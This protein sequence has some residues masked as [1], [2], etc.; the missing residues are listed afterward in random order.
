MKSE[1]DLD[2][3][4]RN[5]RYTYPHIFISPRR[6]W[7]FLTPELIRDTMNKLSPY[8]YTQSN[9]DVDIRLTQAM[10]N[11][12]LHF[13]DYH[14]PLICDT[15]CVG[16]TASTLSSV[17]VRDKLPLPLPLSRKVGKLVF[18]LS[19]LASHPSVSSSSL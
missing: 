17:S 9:C 7:R 19:A 18:A 3:N 5:F 13:Q 14:K 1:Q 2:E 12:Y 6:E 8:K 15:R 4:N 10:E 16:A 11:A